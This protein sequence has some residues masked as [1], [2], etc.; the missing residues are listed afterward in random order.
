M[1]ATP[2]TVLASPAPAGAAG[3]SKA[4]AD[5]GLQYCKGLQQW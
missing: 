5:A 4:N 2:A 3:N 1:L